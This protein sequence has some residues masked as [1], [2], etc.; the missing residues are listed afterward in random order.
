M[1]SGI[2]TMIISPR[3]WGKTSL[4]MEGT[5]QLVRKHKNIKVCHLDL[6]KVRDEADFFESYAK[7]VLKASSGRWQEWV[8]TA[9]ELLGGVVS[10]LT[11]G[12]DPSTEFSL[13][14]SWEKGQKEDH[15]ILALPAKIARKKNIRF[16]I[17]IDEFQKIADFDNSLEL[18]QKLRSHWQ[19]Q[20]DVTFCLFG[21][22]RHVLTELFTSQSQPF[23]QFGDLIFLQKIE[24]KHWQRYVRNQFRKSGKDIDRETIDQLLRVTD[25]HPYHVQQLAHHVWRFTETTAG[26]PEFAR[27][28]DELVLNNEILFRREVEGLTSL[29]LNYLDALLNGEKFLTSMDVVKRYRLGSPGNLTNIRAALEAKEVVDFFGKEP[30]FVNPIFAY[31]LKEQFFA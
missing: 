6:F 17:C 18:Q 16:V 10:S 25:S 19:D 21:S 26:T 7:A 13:R 11:L 27:G 1:A 12:T 14:F 8:E 15:D 5:Q 29:Q 20:K 31:W 4:V 23:Y 28:L 9:K 3:R 30:V 24:N 22:K 2:H